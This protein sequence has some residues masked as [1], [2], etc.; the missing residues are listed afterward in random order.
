MCS[1]AGTDDDDFKPKLGRFRDLGKNSGKRYVTRVLNAVG[2][3]NARFHGPQRSL[4]FTGR[5]IGRG[6]HTAAFRNSSAQARFRQRRVVIKARFVKLAGAGFRKAGAHMRYV[7][8]DGVSKEGAPGKLYNAIRDEVDGDKF[9]DQAKND[10]HQFRFIV[11][12][13]DAAELGDMKIYTRDLM[14]Q[15]EKDLGT[16]LDWVAVDHYNTDHP[17]THIIVRGIADDGKDLIIAKDYM[18]SG[19]RERASALMTDELG[20]RHDHEIQSA[21]RREVTQ[22]RFTSID[23]KLLSMADG[24]MIDMRGQPPEGY[25]RFNYA[26]SLGRLEKL[27]DMQLASETEPGIWHLS[28]ETEST[29]RDLGMRG[30]I[31]KTMHAEMTR[32]GKPTLSKDY[33]IFR[34]KDEQSKKIVGKLIGKGLSDELND[35]Y[36]LVVEGVDGKTHYADIGQATDIE[37]YKTGSIIELS[38][39]NTGPR[40]TDHTIAEIANANKGLYSAELHV[41]HDRK[42][43]NE[44]IKAHIRRLEGLRRNNIARRFADGTWEIPDDYLREVSDLVKHQARFSPV[45]VATQSQFSLE[46]QIQATGATWLDRSLLAPSKIPMSNTGFGAEVDDALKQRQAH[47]VE[48]GFAQKTTNGIRYQRDLLKTL[49]QREVSKVAEGISKQT[50]KTFRPAQKGDKIEGVYLKPVELASGRYALI[51]KSKEFKLVPWRS[52]L[53]RARGQVVSGVV[54]GSSISWD[55]GNKRGVGIS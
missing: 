46:V 1:L 8:R 38:P 19:F 45:N 11:S 21:L 5:N 32:S 47:L 15:M 37:A 40:N 9:L 10:R 33:E 17:H 50:G 49:E 2:K 43:S 30:D 23:R 20:P 25:A 31:I 14:D 24:G 27:R 34:P 44:F 41:R 18:A 29:L 16:K 42:A 6:N 53:E 4:G 52:V 12:P 3:K 39:K 26:L 48:E 28:S 35:R 22:D 7:Q 55:I 51:E 13:E 54:G 36:Y